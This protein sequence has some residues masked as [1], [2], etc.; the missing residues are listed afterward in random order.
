MRTPTWPLVSAQ[1][2]RALDAFTIE[3]QGVPTRV[4]TALDIRQVAEPFVRRR[5]ITHLEKGR[6]HVQRAELRAVT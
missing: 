3:Q 2:M 5:A 4:L 6:V 1:E